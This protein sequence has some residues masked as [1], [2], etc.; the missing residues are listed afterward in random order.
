[1]NISNKFLEDEVRNGF[2]VP[3]I[4]KQAWAAELEMLSDFDQLCKDNSITYFADFG[5]LLGAVRHNGF[6]PWDD[7]IDLV[8]KR[9][10]YNK[11]LGVINT[12][13]SNY[14]L[15]TFRNEDGFKEFHSVLVNTE[16]ACFTEEHYNKYHGFF[17]TCGIDIYILDKIS[18]DPSKEKKRCDDIMFLLAFA[19][20]M[21]ENKFSEDI[22]KSNLKEIEKRYNLTI[23]Y[24]LDYKS[25]W[26]TL[27]DLIEQIC[28]GKYIDYDTDSL[29]CVVPNLL[30]GRYD[31]M[32]TPIDYA[33]NTFIK[34]ENIDIS[35]PKNYHSLLTQKFGDYKTIIKN[36]MSHD[37]PYFEKQ[38]LLLENAASCSINSFTFE[39][40][41][42]QNIGDSNPS[43]SWKSVISECIDNLHILLSQIQNKPSERENLIANSQDLCIELG[44]LIETIKGDG[45][46]TVHLIEKHCEILYKLYIDLENPH[47]NLSTL[48]KSFDN[49]CKS[50]DSEV[51]G[52]KEIF[53][54][55]FKGEY[56]STLQCTYLEYKNNPEYDVYVMPIPYFYKKYDGSLYDMQFDTTAYPSDLPI[57]DWQTVQ[58]EFRRPDVIVI[59]NPYDQFNYSTSI[60]PDFYSNILRQYTN[61][62]LY[63]PWFQTDSFTKE[64]Y[65]SY[66]NMNYYVTMPGVV[67]SDFVSIQDDILKKTYL[68]KLTEWSNESYRD[69]WLN[70]IK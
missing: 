43:D 63:I 5:T 7:D 42:N 33:E 44:T 61:K 13:P 46:Q 12:L 50:I 8:M 49:I 14:S 16:H 64:D 65:C 22:I 36:T 41:L 48:E 68:D 58:L 21:I 17:Y 52:K 67:N 6:I 59:Q 24:T 37:Y 57:I 35:V 30:T 19:D 28:L 32:H 66:K 25:I 10:D 51:L 69:K 40:Y 2:Y 70:I 38:K 23:N 27:Y 31:R 60:H 1:M 53:F 39:K 20:G 9:E 55:P 3:S 62:L 18:S 54:L 15:H 56:W 29:I 34:F 45:H 26:I 4:M 47:L 11:L